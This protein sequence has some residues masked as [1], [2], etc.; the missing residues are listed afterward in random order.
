M[1]QDNVAKGFFPKGFVPVVAAGFCWSLGAI[2]IKHMVDPYSYRLPYLSFRGLSIAFV[3]LLYLFIKEGPAFVKNFAKLGKSGLIGA[4]SLVMAFYGFVFS[5]TMTTAAL[6][7]FMVALTPFIAS[8]IGYI[9]L[10]E[11]VRPRTIVSIVIAFT[12]VMVMVS[13]GTVGGTLWGGLVGFLSAVGFAV[14]SV[15]LRWRPETPKFTTSATAGLLCGLLSWLICLVLGIEFQMP[16]ININ[17]SLVNGSVLGLGFLLYSMGAKYLS[18]A[19]ATVLA[20]LEVV[21]GVFWVWLPIIGINETPS[22][23]TLLGGIMILMA[24]AL[25]SFAVKKVIQ[26]PI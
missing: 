17:L 8:I 6:A 2:F 14:Y 3:L 15:T 26:P 7:L 10:K 13:E 19:E 11:T 4:C 16:A 1:S 25:H 9:V 21:G 20:Q 24:I 12:G 23:T 22:A 18:A 5:V